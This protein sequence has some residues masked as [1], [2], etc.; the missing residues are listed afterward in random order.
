MKKQD[1]IAELSGVK[2]TFGKQNVHIENSYQITDD[3]DKV[4][5]IKGIFVLCPEI[6]DY[7]T[8]DNMLTEWKAHNILFQHKYK[9]ART[10][11]VDFEYRQNKWHKIGF[12]ILTA[13]IK[14][15]QK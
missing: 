1:V 7:R 12:A 9:Q 8:I 6:K 15:K 11:D 2:I 14:E 10:K 13:F 4:K 3:N 5:I